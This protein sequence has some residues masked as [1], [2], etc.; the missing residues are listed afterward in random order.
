[1]SCPLKFEQNSAIQKHPMCDH[2]AYLFH[3]NCSFIISYVVDILRTI[4]SDVLDEKMFCPIT[5]HLELMTVSWACCQPA[6][7]FISRTLMMAKGIF[8]D[9]LKDVRVRK[10]QV[11]EVIVPCQFSTKYLIT[12][13]LIGKDCLLCSAISL[14]KWQ[15]RLLPIKG[16][17]TVQ[18]IH[19]SGLR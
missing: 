18:F 4:S 9:L 8:W 7:P 11:Y 1:M 3:G 16:G 12:S 17:S 13:Q 2:F 5:Q 19:C 14:G 6:L 10:C 15:T